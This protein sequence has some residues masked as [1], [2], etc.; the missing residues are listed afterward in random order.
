MALTT[1]YYTT[2]TIPVMALENV[3][4]CRV[5][6]AVVLG[7]MSAGAGAEQEDRMVLTTLAWRTTESDNT[8]F[9][10]K[11]HASNRL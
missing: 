1:D 5:H 9:Q 10:L 3:M 6:R 2:A 11:E 4:T 7:V 8:T